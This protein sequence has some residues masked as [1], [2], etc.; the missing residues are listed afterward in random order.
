MVFFM[1]GPESGPA[2][3]KL[4]S[5]ESAMRFT[6]GVCVALLVGGAGLA[7][8]MVGVNGSKVRFPAQIEVPNGGKPVKLALTGAALRTRT[9]INQYAVASYLQEGVK[10]KS[11]EQLAAADTYKALH[12]ILESNLSG[13]ELAESLSAAIRANAPKAFASE[14]QQLRAIL[15]DQTLKA[16]QEIMLTWLPKSGVRFQVKGKTDVQV[17]NPAFA[18]ALWE[19]YLGGSHQGDSVKSGLISRLQ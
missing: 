4:Y 16:G 2:T 9:I 17:A 1:V 3:W 19:A 8:E 11:A 14:L 6:G 15:G 12:L 13:R 5:L 7:A 10:A 18:R